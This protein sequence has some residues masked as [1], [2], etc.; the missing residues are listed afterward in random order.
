[1]NPMNLILFVMAPINATLLILLYY[2][3]YLKR[4]KQQPR[5]LTKKTG[6]VW[7][8]LCAILCTLGLFVLLIETGIGLGVFITPMLIL[9]VILTA[10]A[11]YLTYK[12]FYKQANDS[13]NEKG[14]RKKIVSYALALTLFGYLGIALVHFDIIGDVRG[15]SYISEM[16]PVYNKDGTLKHDRH[17]NVV[18]DTY[19][20]YET[21]P[22]TLEGDNR[23][24]FFFGLCANIGSIGALFALEIDNKKK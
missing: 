14:I 16:T 2:D 18:Y 20:D 13:K 24:Y 23:L 12:R 17:G 10:I 7:L 8:L 4:I 6:L 22:G 19:Y 21:I 9:S 5:K 1:M 3:L 15:D 11:I